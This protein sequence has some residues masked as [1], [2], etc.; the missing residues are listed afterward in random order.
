M[1]ARNPQMD[2]AAPADWLTALLREPAESQRVASGGSEVE[3][4]IWGQR[5]LPGLF[6]LQGAGA[7]AR[8]WDGVASPLARYYPVA[9]LPLPGHAASCSRQTHSGAAFPKASTSRVHAAS[10]PATRAHSTDD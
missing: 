8:W 7:H 4:L 10:L 6:L 1:H 3:P 5:G 9:A 2:L